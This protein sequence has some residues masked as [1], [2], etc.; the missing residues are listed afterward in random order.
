[1]NE[2]K[3]AQAHDRLVTLSYQLAGVLN[4]MQVQGDI[5]A[6][7]A[8]TVRHLLKQHNAAARTRKE[9]LNEA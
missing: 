3:L 2:T 5:P 4:Q 6:W 7:Y 8:E 1:M 9:A